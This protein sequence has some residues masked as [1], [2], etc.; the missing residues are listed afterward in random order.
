M[1]TSFSSHATSVP[2]HL[3]HSTVLRVSCLYSSPLFLPLAVPEASL[4]HLLLLW[5]LFMLFPRE[6][7]SRPLTQSGRILS[8]PSDHDGCCE[9]RLCTQCWLIRRLWEDERKLRKCSNGHNERIRIGVCSIV[10]L[11]FEK[12]P[13]F[14]ILFSPFYNLFTQ[15]LYCSQNSCHPHDPFPDMIVLRHRI[16]WLNQVLLK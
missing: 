4:S 1:P 2:S 5:L 7:L 14:R 13:F 8:Y 12:K 3:I 15:I 10:K 16:M 6:S 9:P 11:K